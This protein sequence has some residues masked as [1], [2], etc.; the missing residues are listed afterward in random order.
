M[1]HWFLHG[2]TSSLL[3]EAPDPQDLHQV[4]LV[5]Y[6]GARL[7]ESAA[8]G[9]PWR[10]GRGVPP[11]SFDRIP[12][13]SVFPSLGFGDSGGPA[14]R[15]HRQGRDFGF[16]SDRFA[17][18]PN[19]AANGLVI[20]IDDDSSRVGVTV[21]LQLDINDVLHITTSL[22]NEGDSPLQVDALASAS[23]Y[24]PC[25]MALVHSFFGQ[26]S[27]EFQWQTESLSQ[28]HWHQES[29]AGRTSHQRFPG[30]VVATRQTDHHQG[31]CY[32]AHLAWSGN[33][34]QTIVS[35]DDGMHQW[36]LGVHLAPGELALA[37]GAQWT[38]PP[39]MASFST[40]GRN[41]LMQN[42]HAAMRATLQWP[43]GQFTP[44]PVHLNT[45][46]AV[47][48][49]HK[50]E[51]LKDFATQAA[52]IGVE[53]FIL[54]DGW[55]HGRHDDRTSLGDW[56]PDAGKYPDGLA[57]LAQHVTGLGMEFGLWVEPEMVNPDSDLYRAHPEWAFAAPGKRQQTWRNQLVLN[58][59][60]PEVQN[61]LFD[62]LDALLGTLPIRYLK[63][64]M[65]RDLT[66]AVGADGRAG[67]MGFV[68]GLYA[69]LARVRAAHPNVEIESC[70]SGGGRMDAGVLAHTHR[71]WTSDNTDA[72]S[73]VDIQ[74]GALAFFPPE[75]LGAHIG[76]TPYHT[77][78]RTQLLDFRAGVAL[79]L[80]LG[81][82][83][84]VR[85]LDAAQRGQLLRWVDLYKFLRQRTH[86]G[87]VWLGECGDHIVWQAH[88]QPDNLLVFVTRKTPTSARQS[89]PLL[90]PM[91]DRNAHYAI[92]RL[93]PVGEAVANA[94][95]DSPLH[96]GLRQGQT[97]EVHGAW[98]ALSGLPLSRMAGESVHIFEVKK[99]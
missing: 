69:L 57:P 81:I 14:L 27:N 98:L 28:T 77:T 90:L 6:W 49:D 41:G 83:L 12:A 74:R 39:V 61:Y 51:D 78:G 95:V 21:T 80:H 91:L 37:P 79:P 42:F 89:P 60:L 24:L 63:W 45:W 96:Q 70:A 4:P 86:Q 19:L 64:D 87:Q 33:H 58:T 46:E 55:F 43:A 88:G 10:E 3:L 85:N 36:R 82:E 66:Q 71:F 50:L 59:V 72:L 65:N 67:Y 20:R 93:D 97:V 53:R 40:E 44:R 17:V 75:V 76:P 16:S 9:F 30:A 18:T 94:G 2:H 62:K 23:L 29:V 99:A 31:A 84:D 8:P 68:Q 48:F 5:R 35:L 52:S 47:Y 32:G 11:S 13:H 38:A 22:L 26:W 56:W 7:P 73:R 92:R 34:Q 1:F 15:A 25:G 54:D